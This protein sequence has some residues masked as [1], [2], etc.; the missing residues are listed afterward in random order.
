MA[1][2]KKTNAEKQGEYTAGRDNDPQRRD[3]YLEK[4]RA[5]WL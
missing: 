2:V 5:F 4:E 1:K 3:E